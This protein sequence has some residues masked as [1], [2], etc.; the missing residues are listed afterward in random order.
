MLR[1]ERYYV[2]CVM[3]IR[4]EGAWDHCCR[5]EASMRHLPAKWPLK[6]VDRVESPSVDDYLQT[7]D[8]LNTHWVRDLAYSELD[9]NAFARDVVCWQELLDCE[10]L[11]E[12]E[13][14]RG[15]VACRA[16]QFNI[17]DN[18]LDRADFDCVRKLDLNFRFVL[19]VDCMFRLKREHDH[20][21]RLHNVVSRIRLHSD[22]ASARS[23]C[24]SIL[25]HGDVAVV[26][27]VDV[28][29]HRVGGSLVVWLR[30]REY[31]DCG[32]IVVLHVGVTCLDLEGVI[33]QVD[34]QVSQLFCVVL[35]VSEHI[36]RHY[37]LY[38]AH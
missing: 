23:E 34:V 3:S 20:S 37:P 36:E 12:A 32:N 26:L 11:L 13:A 14:L 7:I 29:V 30:K 2:V 21:R 38:F 35:V 18:T 10:C 9:F 22:L 33:F 25:D 15:D 8:F 16:C 5:C 24:N 1:S 28:N 31:V 6:F 27:R 17:L 4:N 19:L